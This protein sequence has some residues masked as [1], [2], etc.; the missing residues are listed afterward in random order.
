M[1][2]PPQH[3]IRYFGELTESSIHGRGRRPFQRPGAAPRYARDRV[4]DVRHIRLDL[5]FDFDA[6][7][8]HGRC[9][10]TFAPI[11]DGIECFELDAVELTI[12]RVQLGKT[13]LAFTHDGR[14]LRITLDRAYRDGEDVTI[15]IDYDA[16]PRRGLYFIGP[17]ATHPDKPQEIWTQGEDED[18]RYWFPCHDYP[19]QRATSEI[20]ATAPKGMLAVSNGKLLEVRDG[21]AGARIFHWRQEIAHPAYLMTLCVGP[22]VEITESYDGIPVVYYVHQAREE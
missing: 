11:N 9:T 17:D 2:R 15:E 4:T 7:R 8:V 21:A 3:S 19:N 6:K 16:Q 20:I 18:S 12:H 22:Y 1:S 13:P 10:T 14:K 5:S